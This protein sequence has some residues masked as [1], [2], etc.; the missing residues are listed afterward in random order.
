MKILVIT[1]MYPSKEYPN[2]GIFVK[3]TVNIL[4]NGGHEITVC[5][6]PKCDAFISKVRCYVKLYLESVIRGIWGKYDC[7]YAHFISH[8]AIPVRIIKKVHKQLV[9]VENAH[10]NDVLIEGIHGSKNLERSRKALQITDWVIVPSDYYKKVVGDTF[11][12]P[13][14]KIFVS[15]SGGVNPTIFAP[16]ERKRARVQ[17]GLQ[18]D[19]FLIGYISRIEKKKGWETFLHGCDKLREKGGIDN[20]KILIV[21][22][23]AERDNLLKLVRLLSLESYVEYRDLA[24]Q[25]YLKWYY[26]ALDVFC[27]PSECESL[28]LV[29]LEAMACG[30]LCVCSDAEGIKTYAEDNKNC[31]MFERKNAKQLAD[32][33]LAAYQMKEDEKQRIRNN[34]LAT[35]SQYST[36]NIEKALLDFFDKKVM[37]S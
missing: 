15:P 8:T 21:G 26:N 14:S 16:I 23:G 1:N 12:F 4:E 6:M 28:G 11:S 27:F 33:L 7:V 31:L 34:A 10:G 5:E 30:T 20:F 37:T 17:I 3:N 13:E 35:A 9:L 2:Y 29:G 25:D 36:S 24:P 32:R 22:N 19:N 18:Q